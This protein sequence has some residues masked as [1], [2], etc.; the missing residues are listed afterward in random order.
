MTRSKFSDEQILAIV[1]E[2]HASR[3]VADLC[4]TRGIGIQDIHIVAS[5]VQTDCPERNGARL[6]CP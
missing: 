5:S 3:M 1:T 2:G 4:R 6:A